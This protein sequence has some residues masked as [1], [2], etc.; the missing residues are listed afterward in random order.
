VPDYA[1]LLDFCLADTAGNPETFQG[2]IGIYEQDGDLLWRTATPISDAQEFRCVEGARGRQLVVRSIFQGTYYLWIVSWIFNQDG[3][4][5]VG[6]DVGGRTQN[7]IIPEGSELEGGELIAPQEFSLNHTHTY[8]FRLD[9]DVDG[10]NNTLIE[11]N[12]ATVNNRKKNQCGQFVDVSETVLKRE[13]DAIR[14]LNP[15][16]NRQWIVIN[17]DRTNRLGHHVGYELVPGKNGYSKSADYS[18]L[19]KQFSFIKHHLHATLYEDN[20]QFASGEM[21]ILQD[22]DTGLGAYVKDNRNI[23]NKDLVLWYTINFAHVPHSE[24]YPH[25]ALY[26]QGFSIVPHNFFESNPGI[27]VPFEPKTCFETDI[28]KE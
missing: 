24:D 8:A 27:T 21:P 11:E 18:T 7:I 12:Q 13:K 16:S 4:M 23:E 10:T 9:F 14:D 3:S 1:E 19:H 5:N 20:Q 25:I 22:K 17:E 15:K 6:I 2:V 28:C 26:R